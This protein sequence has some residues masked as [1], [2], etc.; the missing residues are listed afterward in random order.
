MD[1]RFVIPLL[2]RICEKREWS[3]DEVQANNIK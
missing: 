3:R 2:R 1:G